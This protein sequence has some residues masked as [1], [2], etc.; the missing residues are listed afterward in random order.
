VRGLARFGAA[1][2]RTAVLGHK[3]PFAAQADPSEAHPLRR[4]ALFALLVVDPIFLR[5]KLGM[6]RDAAAKT[7]RQVAASVLARVRL[8]ATRTLVDFATSS[9]SEIEEAA[10]EALKV[11]VP[12]EWAGVLPRPDARAPASFAGA[13]LACRDRQEMRGRYDED[14]FENPR[15]L[16][17]LREID[18]SPRPFALAREALAGAAGALAQSLEE[19]AG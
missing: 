9:P 18:A 15:A 13:L 1:Y 6:S 11:R 2:A 14:W 3:A 19:V 16:H 12:R 5:K 4:G 8:D 17:F 7:A 10:S